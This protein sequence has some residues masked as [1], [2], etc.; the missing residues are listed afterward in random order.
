[1]LLNYI[2]AVVTKHLFTFRAQAWKFYFQ[3]NAETL[4]SPQKKHSAV[5]LQINR[6]S[7]I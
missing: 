4:W 2:I 5:Y 3:L 1:M 6:W 7:I